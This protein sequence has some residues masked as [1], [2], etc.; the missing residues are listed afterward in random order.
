MKGTVS[1]PE[2]NRIIDRTESL[3]LDINREKTDFIEY[4]LIAPGNVMSKL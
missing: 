3:L 4:F 1:N 2:T